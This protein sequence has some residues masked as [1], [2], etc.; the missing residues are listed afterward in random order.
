MR[1]FRY[2]WSATTAP[3]TPRTSTSYA[4]APAPRNA[5]DWHTPLFIILT[6]APKRRTHRTSPPPPPPPTYRNRLRLRRVGFSRRTHPCLETGTHSV[7]R[8]TSK[9]A[10]APAP[11]RGP[12][13]WNRTRRRRS[14]RSTTRWSCE[15]TRNPWSARA[16]APSWRRR[17]AGTTP[18]ACCRRSCT[19]SPLRRSPTWSYCG[20]G[21]ECSS[22]WS[23]WTGG[24]VS[25]RTN[26]K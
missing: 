16:R 5:T 25:R 23:R 21:I 20:S 17:R 4:S 13:P 14:P 24:E 22:A 18:T 9:T 12:S 3:G 7:W 15:G 26:F 8:F 11:I 10:P 19:S 2:G 1:N 6:R